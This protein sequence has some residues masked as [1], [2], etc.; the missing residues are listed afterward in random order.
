MTEPSL[1]LADALKSFSHAVTNG[2]RSYGQETRSQVAQIE[3]EMR[4]IRRERDDALAAMHSTKRNEQLWQ[5][6]IEKWKVAVDKADIANSHQTELIAQLRREAQQWKEQCLRLEETSRQE[7]KDWK[8]QF[9]RVEKERSRLS[10]RLEEVVSEPIIKTS[11][12]PFTPKHTNLLIDPPTASTSTKR[13]STSSAKYVSPTL[14]QTAAVSRTGG[15]S[16]LGS[17]KKTRSPKPKPQSH[18]PSILN[19]AVVEVPVKEEDAD[20]AHDGAEASTS[21]SAS[22]SGRGRRPLGSRRPPGTTSVAASRPSNPRMR[23]N[24]R[25]RLDPESAEEDEEEEEEESGDE[26]E[27]VD[28]T[29]TRRRRRPAHST[30]HKRRPVDD[31]ED[32]LMLGTEDDPAEVYGPHLIVPKGRRPKSITNTVG[33]ITSPVQKRKQRP[34]EAGGGSV[35]KARKRQ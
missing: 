26:S 11:D 3:G 23:P 10:A 25:I 30:N 21:A 12:T 31:D 34:S 2:M 7:I 15:T 5:Q 9:L 20:E 27:Y 17:A 19:R 13:A 18:T 24:K 33:A 29:E 4:Q 14:A 1:V 8:D 35:S 28:E 6:E 22:G 32:E 16:T